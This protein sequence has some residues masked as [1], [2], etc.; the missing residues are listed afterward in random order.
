MLVS[1][2]SSA[3]ADDDELGADD[4]AFGAND[5]GLVA[6]NDWVGTEENEY[7]Q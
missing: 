7:I 2:G 4:G 6:N 1:T 3:Y 5:D